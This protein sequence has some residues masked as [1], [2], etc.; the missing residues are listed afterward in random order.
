MDIENLIKIGLSKNEAIV[1]ANLIKVGETSAHELISKTKLHKGVVY[2]NLERLIEKGL[3]T[4]II[5]EGKKFF[6]PSIPDSLTEF[7]DNEE[8]KI[9]EKRKLIVKIKEQIIEETKHSREKQEATIFKGK[10]AVR[11]FYAE[12]LEK[13]DYY[14][15][16]GPIEGVEIMGELFWDAH[17]LKRRKNKDH[18]Y[19]L[20]NPSLKKWA[21]KQKGKYTH[22]K[23]F[24]GDFEPLT[25]THIQEDYVAI[26]VWTEDP[27][28]FKMNNKQ[29]VNSYKKYFNNMW[30][31]AK[32]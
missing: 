28:I 11:S 24:K 5:K 4:F 25:E 17:H 13:G 3:I 16:G 9:K 21:E 26:I 32:R 31:Q 19:M 14:V 6:Q 10:K 15:F 18:S 8:E 20:F 22:I 30:K 23:Y 1:Y 2:D 27:V 7:I 29:V 12:T